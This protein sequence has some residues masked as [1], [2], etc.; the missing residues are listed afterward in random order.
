[1]W[2]TLGQHALKNKNKRFY[3]VGV[4]IYEPW[5]M[6]CKRNGIQDD[7]IFHLSPLLPCLEL[8]GGLPPAW[9]IE[10]ALGLGHTWLQ[11]SR[12]GTPP[13]YF[14]QLSLLDQ[15]YYPKTKGDAIHRDRG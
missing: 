14:Q 4:D 5:L 15:E 13:I 1:M 7:C 11:L 12:K 3:T 8:P 9:G 10:D 2:G 6:E